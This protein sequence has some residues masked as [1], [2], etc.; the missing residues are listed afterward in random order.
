MHLVDVLVGGL[1]FG[2]V[3]PQFG[4]RGLEK[5]QLA[6]QAEAEYPLSRIRRREGGN[7]VTNTLCF[8]SLQT[9]R[10]GAV[11]VPP[12]LWTTQIVHHGDATC[13]NYEG[14]DGC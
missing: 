12:M 6:R 8:P 3:N 10:P 4:L 13:G 7:F 2:R 5:S 11:P 9:T 1:T 14:N